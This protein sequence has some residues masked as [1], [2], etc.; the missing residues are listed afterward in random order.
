MN[1]RICDINSEYQ[2]E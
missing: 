2:A 1:Y